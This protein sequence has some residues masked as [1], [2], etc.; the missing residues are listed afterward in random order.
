LARKMKE[1]GYLDA[2]GNIIKPFNLPT[3]EEIEGWYSHE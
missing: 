1:F 3:R 2:K